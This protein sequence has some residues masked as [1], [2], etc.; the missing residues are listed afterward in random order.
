MSTNF[1]L[2]YNE[3]DF[4]RDAHAKFGESLSGLCDPELG[5][6]SLVF[7]F[8][9]ICRSKPDMAVDVLDFLETTIAR[10]DAISEIE[11]AIAISFLSYEDLMSLGVRIPAAVLAIAQKQLS[12]DRDGDSDA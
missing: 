3:T 5:I 7:E 1:V 12:I 6:H 10:R 4:V 11:N 9:Q 2:G 8:G